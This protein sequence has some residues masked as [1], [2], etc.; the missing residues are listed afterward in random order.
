M[1]EWVSFITRGTPENKAIVIVKYFLSK[2]KAE[3]AR[4]ISFTSKF[5]HI[6]FTNFDTDQNYFDCNVFPGRQNTKGV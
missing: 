1:F 6:N 2:E 3:K 5:V 4:K